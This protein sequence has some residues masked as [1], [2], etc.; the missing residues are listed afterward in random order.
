ML[1]I[2]EQPLMAG[3]LELSCML[4]ELLCGFP[5]P[6]DVQEWERGGWMCLPSP[7]VRLVEFLGTTPPFFSLHMFSPGSIIPGSTCVHG[8]GAFHLGGFISFAKG[9]ETTSGGPSPDELW[10]DLNGGGVSVD[11]LAG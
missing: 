5:S 6:L 4:V 10:D 8:G 7:R 9:M 11:P 1:L 2:C 3:Q